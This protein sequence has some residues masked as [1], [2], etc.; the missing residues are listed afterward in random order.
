MAM[1][2]LFVYLHYDKNVIINDLSKSY[3]YMHACIYEYDSQRACLSIFQIKE[4][5]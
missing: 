4:H 5:V 1:H 2:L 3:I